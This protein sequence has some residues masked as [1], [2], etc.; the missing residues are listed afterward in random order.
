M[1]SRAEKEQKYSQLKDWMTDNQ[2]NNV[3]VHALVVGS[4]GTWDPNNTRTL[5][6]LKIGTNYSKLFSVLCC[7]DAIKGSHAIWQCRNN[8]R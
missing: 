8:R 7:I 1:K 2:Y 4:L 6:S 5:R 3:T